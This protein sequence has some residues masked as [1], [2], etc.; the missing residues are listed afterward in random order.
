MIESP[1]KLY[2][3][4]TKQCL[5]VTVSRGA[6]GMVWL[7]TFAADGSWAQS[8]VDREVLCTT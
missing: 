6:A 8:G 7:Y 4:F 2:V 1:R 3:L 5:Y